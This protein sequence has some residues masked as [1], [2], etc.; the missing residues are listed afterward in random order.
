MKTQP[1]VN[2]YPVRSDKYL[3][4]SYTIKIHVRQNFYRVRPDKILHDEDF[5]S[6]SYQILH[7]KNSRITGGTVTFYVQLRL[8]YGLFIIASDFVFYIH[9]FMLSNMDASN[10]SH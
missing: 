9:Q 1:Y 6:A 7:D 10:F 5:R 8:N 4:R 2:F 3:I